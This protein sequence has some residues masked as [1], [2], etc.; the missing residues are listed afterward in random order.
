VRGRGS[1][2]PQRT[3]LLL[4]AEEGPAEFQKDGNADG[5]SGGEGPRESGL[6]D[7]PRCLANAAHGQGSQDA[8][9]T[10]I[11]GGVPAASD[12]IAPRGRIHQG[13]TNQ[14]QVDFEG[15]RGVQG[16]VI[17]CALKNI[18]CLHFIEVSV[19]RVRMCV[20]V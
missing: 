19:S 3:T 6:E 12:G 15:G 1:G 10:D 14:G 4:R 18:T 7:T 13:R 5:K 17:M 9:Q 11:G 20:R 16:Q 2:L 8:P